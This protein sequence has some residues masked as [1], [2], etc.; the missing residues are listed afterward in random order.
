MSN[1]FPVGPFETGLITSFSPWLMPVDGFREILNAH[2]HNGAIEKRGGLRRIGYNAHHPT[3]YTSTGDQISSI[4]KADPAVV[5][6]AAAHNFSG[7]DQIYITGGGM[8][9]VE[10]TRFLVSSTN[11]TATTFELQDLSS[12]DIDSTAYITYSGSGR[13]FLSPDLLVMGLATFLNATG[14]EVMVGWDTEKM[15][16]WNYSVQGYTALDDHAT[17][18]TAYLNGGSTDFINHVQW[19]TATQGNV[20][21]FTNGL[22]EASGRNGLMTYDPRLAVPIVRMNP[23]LDGGT[24]FVHGCAGLDIFK[25]RMILFA[26]F[27][28]T[29]AGVGNNT[30][31][32]NR[33][34]WSRISDPGDPASMGTEWD[35]TIRGNG[36]FSDAATSDRYVTH[37]KLQNELI[38]FMTN[39]VWSLRYQ[40]DPIEPFRW[41]RINS[42]FN[43]RAPKGTVGYDRYGLTIGNRGIFMTDG[44]QA[45]RVDDK[46]ERFIDSNISHS[47]FKKIFGHRDYKNNRAL[48]LYPYGTSTT[49]DRALVRDDE[50][51]AYSEYEINANVLG[52][53]TNPNNQD[54]AMNQFPA[55]EIANPFKLPLTA[56]DA[57][58]ERWSDYF[59]DLNYETL[60][61]G[62]YLGEIYQLNFNDDDDGS[63]INMVLDTGDWNPFRD[64]GM[65]AQ[66]EYVD[67]FV[68][69]Q[70]NTRMRVGFYKD[71]ETKFHTEKV[72]DLLPNIRSVAQIVEAET[73][74]PSSS[75]VS[76]T[77]PNHGLSN[78][79]LIYIYNVEG[80]TGLNGGP[81]F[82]SNSEGNTFE[83]VT[84][85]SN[86][87]AY[88]QGGIITFNKFDAGQ[89]YKRIYVGAIGNSHRIRIEVEGD[90]DPFVLHRFIPRFKAVDG[91]QL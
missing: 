89:I 20:L 81:W 86:F 27:E 91:R 70:I 11:V 84:D 43:S 5:T 14:D 67:F 83:I 88:T 38:V 56:L 51:G 57:T 85:A 62:G 29:A 3:T 17:A 2:V 71:S 9:E 63:A 30:Q 79:D 49:N 80:M 64:K 50:T 60:V 40:A 34:R 15:F 31:F 12:V 59:A 78:G 68:D 24:T 87:S 46:I 42:F 82:V 22:V 37:I 6:T 39:S 69:S 44:I 55:S 41:Q 7:G 66:L 45:Q 53:G 77:A 13:V 65:E 61:G 36:G 75:G 47:N 28:G 1:P 32:Y 23:D 10:N 58:V 74:S 48:F 90:N 33:V 73:L 19:N 21:Y 54:L 16:L 35:Q 76:L 8:T 52:D 26:P 18:P 25:E 72:V 4:T